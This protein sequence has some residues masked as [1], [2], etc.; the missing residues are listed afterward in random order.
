MLPRIL[1]EYSYPLNKMITSKISKKKFFREKENFLQFENEFRKHN[2]T[3]LTEIRKLTGMNWKESRI[4]VYPLISKSKPIAIAY[5][6]IVK[7]VGSL[8]YQMFLLVHELTHHNIDFAKK[9]VRLKN[10]I[11]EGH[12]GLEIFI[13]LVSLRIIKKI[14]GEKIVEQIKFIDTKFLL[15]KTVWNKMDHFDKIWF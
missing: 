4:V 15:H 11:M 2:K 7:I 8:E 12:T 13:S 10:K 6:L 14:Y 9:G 3:I 5:P 1:F